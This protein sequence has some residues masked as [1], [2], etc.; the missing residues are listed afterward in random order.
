MVRGGG[1]R[2]PGVH[3][4]PGRR[5][6]VQVPCDRVLLARYLLLV[7]VVV[8]FGL[9]VARCVC[10]TRLGAGAGESCLES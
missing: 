5:R 2:V 10:L 4:H 9:Q 7:H 6:V 3:R 8:T 1:V